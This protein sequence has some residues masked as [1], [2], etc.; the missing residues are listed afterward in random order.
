MTNAILRGASQLQVGAATLALDKQETGGRILDR[1][2]FIRGTMLSGVLAACP[3]MARAADVRAGVKPA[4]PR[5]KTPGMEALTEIFRIGHGPSSSHTM[6]PYAASEKFLKRNPNAARFEVTLYGSLSATGKG[7][8]TDKAITD[9]L[10]ASRTKVI[11]SEEE[12]A[13][14]PNGFELRAY[15]TAGKVIDKWLC[16][17]V[18]GG[19]LAEEGLASSVPKVYA[20]DTMEKIIAWCDANQKPIWGLFDKVEGGA[21]WAH[22]KKVRETMNAAI[23]SGL[24]KQGTLPGG[25]NLAR[26]AQDVYRKSRHFSQDSRRTAQLSAYAFAVNEENAALGVIVTAPTCGSC[27]TLPAVLHYFERAHGIAEDETLA[28][29][30]V[31]GLVGNVAKQNGSISGA[32]AG[33]QAEVGVA[34]AMAAAAASYLMGGT[35]RQCQYAAAM[36]LEHFLGLTCDPVNGLVQIPCIERNAIAANRAMTAA[37][38]SLLSDGTRVFNYDKI[39]KV[40]LETGHDLP[41]IYRETSKGGL[42]R[43]FTGGC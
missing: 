14:H 8:F 32:E 9:V 34:A 17:S 39:V 24:R 40:M 28:A 21:G 19:A 18:G 4:A 1:R 22:L 29:L 31:A 7:H 13:F 2:N 27:G 30:A 37:E 10:G 25:L 20:E 43:H 12:K 36:A 41:A 3:A 6:G 38:L 42:A 5:P 33:C 35:P 11:W 15:D 16:Y 26:R 23:A